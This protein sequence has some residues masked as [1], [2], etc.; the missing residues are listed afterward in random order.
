MNQAIDISWPLSSG[1]CEVALPTVRGRQAE[2]EHITQWIRRLIHRRAGGALWIEGPADIGKSRMLACAADEAALAGAQILAGVGSAGSEMA[3]L[4]P[5]L[6]ALTHDVAGFAHGLRHRSSAQNDSYWLVQ[7]IKNRLRVLTR[8]RPVALFLDGLQDCDELTLVTVRTLTVQL[9]DLPILWVLAARAHSERPAVEA[10][11]RH[12]LT[13]RAAHLEL[14]PL[15]EEAVRSMTQDLL[16]ARAAEA[17]PCLPYLDGLPGAVHH[18]CAQIASEPPATV[19]R[20]LDAPGYEQTVVAPSVLRR[21]EQLSDEARQL[22]Q[23]AAVLGERLSARHLFRVLNRSESALLRPLREVLDARLLSTD[24]DRLSFR[25]ALVRRTVSATLPRPVRQSV[26][27]RSID[28]QLRAGVPAASVAAELVDVAEPGDTRAIEILR[29]AARELAALSPCAAADYL[30]CAMGLVQG[31]PQT[32]QQVAA[33]LLPL[34]WQVGEVGQARELAQEIL[35]APPDPVVH[36]E[37]CLHL[38]RMGSQFRLPRPATHLRHVHRRRDV[39]V[40]LKDQLLSATLLN[41]LL[42]GGVEEPGGG[43]SDTLMRARGVHAVSELT[44]RTLQSMNACHRQNWGDALKHSETAVT[45]IAHLD[46]AH[47]TALPEVALATSWHA[48]VLSLAGHDR[49]ALELVDDGLRTAEARGRRVFLPLWRTA[50]ARLLLDAGRL[51]DAAS[52]LT[53]AQALVA[54]TGLPFTGEAATLC[55]RVQVVRHLGDEAALDQCAAKADAWLTGGDPY[56]RRVGAWLTVVIAAHRSQR[57]AP[58]LLTH[59]A[60]CLRRG[61]VHAVAVDPGDVVMLARAALHSDRRDIA[62]AAVEFAENRARRNPG[63]PLFQAAAAHARGL[64]DGDR[65]RLRTATELYGDARPLLRAEALKDTGELET[66]AVEAQ[67]CFEQ[68]LELYDACGEHPESGRLRNRLRR[69]GIRSTGAVSPA[70]EAGWRGLTPAELG[71][72]RLIAHGATNREAAQRLFLSPHTVN[73][74]LRHAFTKLEVRSRVQL[75]RLYLREVDHS[76]GEP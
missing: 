26:R 42:T 56:Q 51:T 30:H 61:F 25:H 36:A 47:A 43:M 22:V 54:T 16:G 11:R 53:S 74:H 62:G 45:G 15:P 49:A 33:E 48:S 64:F 46:L 3:P 40:A 31:A 21:L 55:T 18:V 71:V 17:A 4:A 57:P 32:R 73:T 35:Q 37:A 75:A 13:G 76:V 39:P 24:Q 60:A 44:L 50:R 29:A 5:L 9:A 28:L 23:I 41:D 66:T 70:A 38:V 58:Q 72:V 63:F 2:Q 34:L 27:R 52:E 8:E 14:R 59:A 65:D 19:P 20:A 1:A 12:L 68:A 6:D 69:L 67:A 7:E 10:L